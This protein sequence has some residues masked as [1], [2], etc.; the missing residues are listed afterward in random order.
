[1]SLLD[2]FRERTMP[3]NDMRVAEASELP[4]IRSLRDHMAEVVQARAILASKASEKNI[5][6]QEMNQRVEKRDIARG[7]LSKR[8]RDMAAE[9]RLPDRQIPEA[10]EV[11]R[12]DLH[13]QILQERVNTAEARRSEAERYLNERVAEMEAAWVRVGEAISSKLLE[14]YRAAALALAAAHA[15]YLAL[16]GHFYYRWRGSAWPFFDKKLA[17]IDPKAI[18]D[19]ARTLLINPLD[20]EMAKK[21]P[22]C[23][24]ET[25][26]VVEQLR[27]GVE[28]AKESSGG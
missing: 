16:K 10:E 17:L 2:F 9:N 14:D 12:L 11:S 22:G 26:Q 28:A 24:R 23:A 19:G 20:W 13:I 5:A 15:T 4:E 8:I 18:T 3:T 7:K 1:M 25:L 21:W 6:V 27:A